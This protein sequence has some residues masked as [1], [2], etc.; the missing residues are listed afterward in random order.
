LLQNIPAGQLRS[1]DFNTKPIGTGPF[2]WRFINVTGNSDTTRQQEITLAPNAHYYAG[3]PLLDGFD[4][5]VYRSDQQMIKAFNAKQ[6]SAMSGLDSIPSGMDKNLNYY[7]VP[8]NA[9][10]MAFFNN[11]HGALGNADVRKALVGGVDRN[12]IVKLSGYPVNLVNGPLLSSQIT[13][14]SGEKQLPYNLKSAQ[15]LLDSAGW[16]MG[17]DGFRHKGGQTLSL[18]MV[19]EN[20]PQYEAVAQYLQGQWAKLGVRIGVVNAQSEDLQGNI[21]PNHDYD[22][23]LYGISLGVDP[24]VFDYW[25]S[26]QAGTDSQGH[27]NL[28]EYK[29]SAADEALESARTRS[30]LSLR[31]PKYHQFLKT[32]RNDAPALALYQPNYLYISRSPVFGFQYKAMDSPADRFYNVSNWMIREQRRSN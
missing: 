28:S 8:L 16:K 6:I 14:A 27:L 7:N 24:D 32:W 1:D 29:S 11:S 22:I 30:K 3:R 26:S 12:Q 20:T 21:I 15:K 4:I 9:I 25:D 17:A 13:Y 5:S 31:L 19:S 23:L 10:T 18:R 2:V